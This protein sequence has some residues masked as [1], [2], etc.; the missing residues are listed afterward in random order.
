VEC[1]VSRVALRS[2]GV[3]GKFVALQRDGLG[4]QVQLITVITHDPESTA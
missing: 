2:D 1:G 3:Y 4:D